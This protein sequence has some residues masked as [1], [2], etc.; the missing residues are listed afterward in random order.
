MKYMIYIKDLLPESFVD[1]IG[2]REVIFCTGCDFKCKNCHNEQIWDM[3]SGY[4][5][6]IQ[7]IYDNLSINKNSMVSGVTFS[8][9]EPMQQAKAFY[10]LGKMIKNN[11]QWNIWCYT[12]YL[13]EDIINSKD[14]KYE[15]LQIIDVL[16]DGI[17]MH[18]LRDLT[19]AFRGSKNQR[20]I[21]VQDS[22]RQNK[23]IE[24]NYDK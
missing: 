13:F 18:E 9:G 12:G 21:D 5:I 14:E 8:G 19:L 6:P 16:V 22:L 23:V 17:Y 15:L 4:L 7:E 10:E 1:G 24:L 2:V 20:I 3:N 11:S